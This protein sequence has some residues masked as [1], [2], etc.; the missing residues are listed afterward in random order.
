[1]QIKWSST[2]LYSVLRRSFFNREFSNE[3]LV[4]S[5]FFCMQNF[6]QSINFRCMFGVGVEAS[7]KN[8]L[9]W[10]IEGQIDLA[11]QEVLKRIWPPMDQYRMVFIQTF[12]WTPNMQPTA[13][14]FG[15]S[16]K[17]YRICKILYAENLAHNGNS[18]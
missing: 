7:T 10:F 18:S 4:G 14:M 1:M 12:T 13:F 15:K 6:L 8:F 16:P 3:F 9:Y 11:C 17:T 2:V 5:C